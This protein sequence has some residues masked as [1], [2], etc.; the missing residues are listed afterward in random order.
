MPIALPDMPQT[1]AA[2]MQMTNAFRAENRLGAVVPSARLQTAAKAFAD[3]LARSGAFAHTADGRQPAERA[4]AAGYQ[5]CIVAENLAMHQ[6]NRG[7]ETVDLAQRA[8]EGWKN[9]PPHRANLLQPHVTETGI[10]IARSGDTN[11]K[12]LTVQLFGRPSSFKYSIAIENISGAAVSYL[13]DDQKNTIADAMHVTHTACVPHELTFDIGKV[14]S[15]YQ[16]RDGET[17][18][19]ARGPDGKVHVDLEKP[20]PSSA[21][22]PSAAT[23]SLVSARSSKAR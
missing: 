20:K 16:A 5:Y 6:S 14:T 22:T 11:P 1:E 9:S 10:G 2:I 23:S 17:F 3:Y 12:F 7:F 19:I 15:K 4:T 8:V 21:A 13:I 18:V